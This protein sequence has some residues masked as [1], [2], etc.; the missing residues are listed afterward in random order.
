MSV[1]IVGIPSGLS[2][3]MWQ[4][5]ELK[6]K[7][8]YAYYEIMDNYVVFY[9]REFGPKETKNIKLDFKTEVKGNYQAPASSAYLYYSDENKFWEKGSKINVW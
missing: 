1:A 4:L 2:V 5:E 7:K 8:M 3:Q 9:W 6:E